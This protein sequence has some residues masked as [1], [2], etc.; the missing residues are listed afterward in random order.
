MTFEQAKKIF[1]NAG[2]DLYEMQ[3]VSFPHTWKNLWKP[4]SISI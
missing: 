4:I 2:L 3:F 1:Q